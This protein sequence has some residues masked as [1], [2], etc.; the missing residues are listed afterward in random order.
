M[1]GSLN[2]NLENGKPVFTY[3][4]DTTI[5]S[6]ALLLL[7]LKPGSWWFD[8]KLGNKVYTL[9]SKPKTALMVDA[10]IS[11]LNQTLKILLDKK[12]AKK[13]EIQAENDSVDQHR[14]N[15][16]IQITELDGSITVIALPLTIV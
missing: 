8:P 15:T 2:I 9:I 3:D 6:N 13:I 12:R 16:T 5:K 11:S 1:T 10:V 14:I 7:L 4:K